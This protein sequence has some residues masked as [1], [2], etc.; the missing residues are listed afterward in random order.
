MK[1]MKVDS[2]PMKLG[3]DVCRDCEWEKLHHTKA[4]CSSCTY[5]VGAETSH[6]KAKTQDIFRE[7]ISPLASDRP[8]PLDVEGA[9]Q[10][11]AR[12]VTGQ[13]SPPSFEQLVDEQLGQIREILLRKNVG[14]GNSALEPIRVFSKASPIE[15]ILVR[16]DDKLSRIRTGTKDREDTKRDLIGYLVL[17]LIAEE[18]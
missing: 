18:S 16:I 13:N 2:A 11:F 1:P 9:A 7:S 10:A 12:V 8:F 3:V 17:L 6:F 4:P 5:G 15:Q 14:Y